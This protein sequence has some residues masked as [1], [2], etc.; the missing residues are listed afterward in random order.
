M[1]AKCLPPSLIGRFKVIY[2]A[3][4]WKK[5]VS[6]DLQKEELPEQFPVVDRRRSRLPQPDFTVYKK[7]NAYP[8]TEYFFVG[9]SFNL[10]DS[11]A[12]AEHKIQRI[13]AIKQLFSEQAQLIS[14][15]ITL[16]NPTF[17]S[18][19]S[20]VEHDWLGRLPETALI[21]LAINGQG[22]LVPE[23]FTVWRKEMRRATAL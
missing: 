9:H 18:V 15:P 1:A 16:T 13:S 12:T 2:A 6:E 22:Q 5:A 10:E 14:V 23:S 19:L 20:K 8:G 21:G 11:A 4:D 3:Q 7:A 17:C